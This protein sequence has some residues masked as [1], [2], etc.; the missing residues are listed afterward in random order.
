MCDDHQ[1]ESKVRIAKP[2]NTEV[3]FSLLRY[4]NQ[5]S[6]IP[7][8]GQSSYF[9][10]ISIGSKTAIMHRVRGLLDTGTELNLTSKHSLPTD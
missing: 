7:F 5:T 1:L 10:C 6:I 8:T 2:E 3:R 9:L 4:K